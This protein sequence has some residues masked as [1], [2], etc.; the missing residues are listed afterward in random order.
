MTKPNT[1]TETAFAIRCIRE[2]YVQ[3]GHGAGCCLE[4]VLEIGNLGDRSIV[5]SIKLAKHR[6]HKDCERLGRIIFTLS[7]TQRLKLSGIVTSK[8]ST[9]EEKK[10]DRKKFFF[11]GELKGSSTT[12]VRE[13]LRDDWC[14][15]YDID[16][17]EILSAHSE[18]DGYGGSG[19][20]LLRMRDTSSLFEVAASHCSCHGFEDQ[21]DPR[22]SSVAYLL[23]KHFYVT[24]LDTAKFQLWLANQLVVKLSTK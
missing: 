15:G 16:K 19:W 14:A 3:P 24:G 22:P 7:L 5:Y 1:I 10:R 6:G 23:S 17:Y 8:G 4:N 13:W 20:A 18:H 2:F 21:F 9:Q 11:T 12:K